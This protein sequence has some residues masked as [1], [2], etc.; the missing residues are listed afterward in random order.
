MKQEYKEKRNK[1]RQESCAKKV[2]TLYGTEILVNEKNWITK[3]NK[4]F[5]YFT[6]LQNALED[7]AYG[8]E[9][10][11]IRSDLETSIKEIKKMHQ[12]FIKALT[13]S[14]ASLERTK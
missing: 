6:T 8:I 13:H 4:H 12:E 3:N 2:M 5:C 1:A 11:K 14:V 9:K 10:G 7:I